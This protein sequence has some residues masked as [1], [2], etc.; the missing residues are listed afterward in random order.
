MEPRPTGRRRGRPGLR[1]LPAAVV[2]LLLGACG[3]SADSTST[4]P[5]VPPTTPP[6][7]A[8]DTTTPT[9]VAPRTSSPPSTRPAVRSRREATRALCQGIDAAAVA[10]SDG[11]LAAGGLRL[12][13]AVS[14]YG[15]D[16]DPAVAGPARRM[17]SS[18]LGG[19][20][21]TSAAAAEE[22]RDA[23]ARHGTTVRLPGGVQCV[24]TPCP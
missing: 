11:R 5:T 21:E 1:L 6:G 10:V 8:A 3:S 14:T 15:A 19:D 16:A 9:T 22:A 20:L 17:L 12:S 4:L 2:A 7:P 18:A 23:C 24:T 13:G